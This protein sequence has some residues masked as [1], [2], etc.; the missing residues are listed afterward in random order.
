MKIYFR[1]FFLSGG[2]F[3][4]PVRPHEF[5]RPF[6][7]TA[8]HSLSL[9][10]QTSS[11][12]TCVVPSTFLWCNY[13]SIPNYYTSLVG[14]VDQPFRLSSPSSFT[15]SPFSLRRSKGRLTVVRYVFIVFDIFLVRGRQTGERRHQSISFH[16]QYGPHTS[17][18]STHSP[19]RP[20]YESWTARSRL[21]QNGYRTRVNVILRP[22]RFTLWWS[23]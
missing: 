19:A 14:S 2:F 22:R 3:F 10:C 17:L 1:R 4:L 8:K 9:R 20:P 18:V 12:I 7:N 16:R 13:Y 11:L 23:L 5:S 15:P 6:A 21:V